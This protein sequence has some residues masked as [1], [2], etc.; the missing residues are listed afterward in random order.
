M[1]K[2]IRHGVFETNSSSTHS[3]SIKQCSSN[4]P[5]EE[6]CSFE[7]RS[8]LAKVVWLLGHI[9]NAENLFEYQV[10]EEKQNLNDIRI[11]KEIIKD[12]Q[13]YMPE[14]IQELNELYDGDILANADTIDLHDKLVDMGCVVFSYGNGYNY[15]NTYE[16]ICLLRRFKNILINIYAEIENITKDQ[17]MENI[18]HEAFGIS[19]DQRDKLLNP[20]TRNEMVKKVK[21]V[22]YLFKDI[23]NKHKN[24]PIEEIIDIYLKEKEETFYKNRNG[25]ISCCTYFNEGALYDCDCGFDSASR[26][27]S[28]I[29]DAF[30]ITAFPSD[31]EL[32]IASREFLSENYKVVGIEKYCG[33]YLI[34][35]KSIY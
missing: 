7:I 19:R 15:L 23:F 5:I 22:D 20:T 3:L 35:S 10:K 32:I 17:A 31:N 30:S 21:E 4:E 13:E 25:K 1:K 14:L 11:K 27:V 34:G 33:E 28:N 9:D 16:D 18:K 12:I 6:N 8:R 26:I 29:C 2:V 24:K